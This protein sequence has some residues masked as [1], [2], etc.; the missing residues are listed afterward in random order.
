MKQDWLLVPDDLKWTAVR[1]ACSMQGPHWKPQLLLIGDVPSTPTH[2]CCR[3]CAI[4]RAAEV[5]TKS[6]PETPRLAHELKLRGPGE[7]WMLRC[8]RLARVCAHL[9]QG[10]GL[11]F[12]R[13][14]VDEACLDP[15]TERNH[16]KAGPRQL[17]GDP[18]PAN[19]RNL[20]PRI[21]RPDLSR[22]PKPPFSP[23]SPKPYKL[24]INPKKTLTR[25]PIHPK[26]YKTHKP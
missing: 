11:S 26:P 23:E 14:S 13:R 12:P 19:A 9:G 10:A 1:S 16:S 18:R 2:T 21:P 17:L 24:P 5:F 20:K 7:S 8:R 22:L 15:P 4:A 25:N 6:S 3:Q